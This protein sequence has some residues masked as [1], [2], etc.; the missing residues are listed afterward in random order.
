MCGQIAHNKAVSTPQP[1]LLTK[2]PV[3]RAE[4]G[5]ALRRTQEGLLEA[6]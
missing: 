4:G 3:T 6:K 5:Q 2:V 1:N